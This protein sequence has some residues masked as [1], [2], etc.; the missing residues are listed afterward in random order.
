MTTLLSLVV[1]SAL[2]TWFTLL[3]ASLI[4]A[5]GW[6]MPG[7]MLAFGNREN[8][9]ELTGLC[10]RADRTAHNMLENF[11]LFAALALTAQLSGATDPRITTGAELFFWARVAFV[12][13][14]Y[15]GLK[16][17]RTGLWL[18]SVAGMGMMVM[19]MMK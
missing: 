5:K 18:V 2:L 11:V 4:R 3:A 19:G 16:Y 17:V 13:V 7:V 8:M 9:P 12:P 10:G 1:Y 6:T 15:A 14:Y